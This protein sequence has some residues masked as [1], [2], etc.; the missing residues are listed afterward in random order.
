L[1]PKFIDDKGLV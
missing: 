1:T